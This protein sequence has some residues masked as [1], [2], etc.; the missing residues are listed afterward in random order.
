MDITEN[1]GSGEHVVMAV[2]YDRYFLAKG[3]SPED[4]GANL[5]IGLDNIF[6]AYWVEGKT[7][8]FKQMYRAKFDNP[9][10]FNA[11]KGAEKYGMIMPMFTDGSNF[12]EVSE[13]EFNDI[14]DVANSMDEICEN[15]TGSYDG[16]VYLVC[17]VFDPETVKAYVAAL[18]QTETPVYLFEVHHKD[19]VKM[20]SCSF[21]TMELYPELAKKISEDFPEAVVY[22]TGAE[23][24]FEIYK[25]GK[26]LFHGPGRKEFDK[27]AEVHSLNAGGWSSVD[28][29]GDMNIGVEI[30]DK[31][32]GLPVGLESVVNVSEYTSP[33]DIEKDTN[34]MIICPFFEDENKKDIKRAIGA[35]LEER[36]IGSN[37]I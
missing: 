19:D 32:T 30:V 14:Q 11:I 3:N 6:D 10:L 16:T 29:F 37:E 18:D 33:D 36:E 12:W 31:A 17:N 26:E 15:K 21:N 7:R 35:Y 23:P 20:D 4:A 34:Y 5:K 2:A 24:S 27:Y 1:I 25:G 13:R 28:D 9:V 8:D 22:A